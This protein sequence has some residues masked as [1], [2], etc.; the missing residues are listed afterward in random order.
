MLQRDQIV[1]SDITWLSPMV[2]TGPCNNLWQDRDVY[3]EN[4]VEK[5]DFFRRKVCQHRNVRNVL[6]EESNKSFFSFQGTSWLLFTQ[7]L[8]ASIAVSVTNLRCCLKGLVRVYSTLQCTYQMYHQ[9]GLIVWTMKTQE[10]K[11]FYLTDK[12]E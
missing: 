7:N 9:Y 12:T 1:I 6:T 3:V 8:N 11:K 10:R 4:I 2:Q 5:G